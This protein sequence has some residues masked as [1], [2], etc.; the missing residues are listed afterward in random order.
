[1]L[2]KGRDFFVLSFLI[3]FSTLMLSSDKLYF[4]IEERIL[5]NIVG[6]KEAR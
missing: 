6:L 1:M 3:D 5:K 2:M 4:S